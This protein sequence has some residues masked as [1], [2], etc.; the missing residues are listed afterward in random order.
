MKNETMQK[1]RIGLLLIAACI[2]ISSCSIE[3]RLYTKGYH[4]DWLQKKQALKN[5]DSH[6]EKKSQSQI[7]PISTEAQNPERPCAN[8]SSPFFASV[9]IPDASANSSKTAFNSTPVVSS[10]HSNRMIEVDPISSTETKVS[11]ADVI[12]KNKALKRKLLRKYADDT[13]LYVIL[14]LL[15]P[16]LAVFLY[17]GQ[18]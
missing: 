13:I 7:K 14:A 2:F 3:N 1:T 6:T 18:N 17:E 8:T 15:L 12:P 9:T 4:V 11:A 16:P 5:S 10:N